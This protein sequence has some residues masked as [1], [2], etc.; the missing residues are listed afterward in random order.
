MVRRYCPSTLYTSTQFEGIAMQRIFS[1]IA[2]SIRHGGFVLE[3]EDCPNVLSK[4]LGWKPH[5]FRL[6]PSC[7]NSCQR[8]EI[9]GHLQV[10]NLLCRHQIWLLA[11]APTSSPCRKYKYLDKYSD[12]GE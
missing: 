1:L 4:Q 12:R 10:H 11:P 3:A 5:L 6:L 2:E 7:S 8:D 9:R